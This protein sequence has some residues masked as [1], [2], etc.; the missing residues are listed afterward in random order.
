MFVNLRLDLAALI[1]RLGLAAIFIVHGFIKLYQHSPLLEDLTLT[2]QRLL[3]AG[4]LVFGICLLLGL[5][6]RV[7][8]LGIIALQV[9]AILFVTGEYAL[10][11]TTIKKNIGIDYRHVG[12]EYNMVLVAMA[13]SVIILGG[14]R[15]ALDRWFWSYW[16][17]RKASASQAAEASRPVAN[18]G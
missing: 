18:V 3:G 12:P 5:L 1:L 4:E 13:L 11:V 17:R 10:T 7:A 6:T 8:A 2:E 14:G 16:Q 15:F 9:G